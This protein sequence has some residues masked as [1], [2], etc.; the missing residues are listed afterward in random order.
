MV[1]GI[2]TFTHPFADGPYRSSAT[3]LH[4][5]MATAAASKPPTTAKTICFPRRESLRPPELWSEPR[6]VLLYIVA[7]FMIAS[8]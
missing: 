2:C 5:P 4:T 1:L 3:A 8:L 6:L 7:P